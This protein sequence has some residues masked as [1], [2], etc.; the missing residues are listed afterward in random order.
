MN[1]TCNECGHTF[2]IDK[3][4]IP[5]G[6]FSVKCPNCKKVFHV[7]AQ[8]GSDPVKTPEAASDHAAS[9]LTSWEQLKPD[10]EA[11]VKKQVEEVRKEILLSLASLIGDSSQASQINAP[12][13]SEKQALVCESDPAV[14]QQIVFILQRLGYA[15]QTSSHLGETLSRLESGFYDAIITDFVFPDDPEGGQKILNKVNGRKTDERRKMFIVMVSDQIKTLSAQSAFFHGA[16][17][18]VHKSDLRNFERLFQDGIR[19]FSEMY[20]TYYK[21]LEE[22]TERL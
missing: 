21:L 22:S 18:A 15:V 9:K 19:H 2:Q 17:I 12:A 10:A 7:N 14:A 13:Y 16:N 11:S 1:L 3:S 6:A 8:T 20:G 5:S 4:K